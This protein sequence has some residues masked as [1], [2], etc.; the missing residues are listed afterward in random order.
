M[1]AVNVSHTFNLYA[2]FANASYYSVQKGSRG[3]FKKGAHT[4]GILVF[5]KLRLK[6]NFNISHR[7]HLKR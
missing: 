3:G 6:Q 7:N 4:R 1:F 2:S 5:V